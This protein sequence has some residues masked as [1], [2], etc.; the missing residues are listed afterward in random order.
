MLLV[1]RA[2]A[3]ALSLYIKIIFVLVV[4][5]Y[6]LDNVIRTTCCFLGATDWCIEKITQTTAH[7]PWLF[8]NALSSDKQGVFAFLAIKIRYL[9]E[10]VSLK[11]YVQ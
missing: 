4:Q 9:Y 2:V 10:V 8:N 6:S 11:L 5:G 3:A 1:L 7:P